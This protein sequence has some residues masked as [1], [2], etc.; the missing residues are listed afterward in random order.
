MPYSFICHG[1]VDVIQCP[2]NGAR[3][4]GAHRFGAANP[5]RLKPIAGNRPAEGAR[6]LPGTGA[7][8]GFEGDLPGCRHL[9]CLPT[10]RLQSRSRAWVH[11]QTARERRRLAPTGRQRSPPCSRPPMSPVMQMLSAVKVTG[12]QRKGLLARFAV[13]LDCVSGSDRI[14]KP[15]GMGRSFRLCLPGDAGATASAG[16]QQPLFGGAGCRH[17]ISAG[18]A[19]LYRTPARRAEV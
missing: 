9:T 8:Q 3:R 4:S 14:F 7:A 1:P 19:L 5:G 10:T 2:G 18:A 13:V 6:D 17:C 11:A 12:E 16:A 15:I